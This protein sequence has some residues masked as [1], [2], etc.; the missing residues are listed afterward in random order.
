M[1]RTEDLEGFTRL[2]LK[3]DVLGRYHT[4]LDEEKSK[5]KRVDAIFKELTN[6]W[7]KMS[8]PMLS[9]QAI[10]SRIGKL[11]KDYEKNQKYPK[12]MTLQNNWILF[13]TLQK[14]KDYGFV[15]KTKSYII[16][17]KNLKEK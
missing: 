11:I 2:P 17:K 14:L 3:K 9:Q 8:F 6:L 15:K 12:K 16:S 13:L 10:T 5:K 7:K 1:P 4:L